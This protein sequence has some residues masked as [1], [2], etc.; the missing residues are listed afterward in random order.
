MGFSWKK[1]LAFAA[2]I[3]AIV[4]PGIGT[5]V[6]A[7]ILGGS[8]AATAAAVG[9]TVAEVTA[10]VGAATIAAGSTALQ[11]GTVEDVFIS[12]ASAGVASGVNFAAGG[13]VTGAAAG[14]VAGT[15]IRGG[16]ASQVLT[17]AFAAGVGAG[18]QDAIPS[19]PD[20]GKTLGS[21]ART[22]ITSG[23]N[24]DQTLLNTAV[25]ALGT[26]D[27]KQRPAPIES[28]TGGQQVDANTIIGP[29]V[30]GTGDQM[31]STLA[32]MMSTQKP[33]ISN[34]D[35]FK[36][37]VNEELLKS[38]F[39][40]TAQAQPLINQAGRIIG[41]AVGAAGRVL[42][43]VA[44]EI[45]MPAAMRFAANNPQYAAETAQYLSKMGMAGA[46]AAVVT[47]FG[48]SGDTIN[49]PS[50]QLQGLIDQ[51]PKSNLPIVKPETFDPN[52]GTGSDPAKT[53]PTIPKVTTTP[54]R[55]TD[56]GDES[57]RLL[58][59]FP[60]PGTAPA[61]DLSV[62][63]GAEGDPIYTELVAAINSGIDPYVAIAEMAG[64]ARGYNED[65]TSYLNDLVDAA[66]KQGLDAQK[67]V[68]AIVNTSVAPEPEIV[69]EPS[70]SP[71]TVPATF[72][73]IA[74]QTS[75]SVSPVVTT[76]PS[77]VP[78]PGTGPAAG[79]L[80]GSGGKIE[81]PSGGPGPILDIVKSTMPDTEPSSGS[82]SATPSSPETPPSIVPTE[83]PGTIPTTDLDIRPGVGPGVEPV[84]PGTPEIPP[85]LPPVTPAE[86]PP[87]VQPPISP[88]P[89]PEPE[90]E[91]EPPPKRQ[92][93]PTTLYPTITQTPRPRKPSYPI[94]A[95]PSPA[96]LLA[97]A[98][99]AYR[100]AGAIEGAESGKERQKVWNEK[101]LRLKDA[102]GL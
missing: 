6:G 83:I 8:A 14:S 58:A 68:D 89:L 87:G 53:K 69:P 16:D 21:A 94:L 38:Q 45:V 75:P 102:L 2:P 18:V 9:L 88:E 78:S 11:G 56:T 46:A 27:D 28:R 52:I 26:L 7:A 70:V 13:G 71:E 23:G 93:P 10:A 91:P 37:F 86:I 67:S 47:S 40:Q 19:N 43:P 92:A 100:P 24:V 97:D 36:S 22:Y 99:A 31:A 15:A 4:V 32:G 35:D 80:I 98:L 65:P 59:R 61:S 33:E 77:S 72:P 12:A 96:R 39:D 74:P 82:S 29:S 66:A 49:L 57:A 5:A 44:E 85:E 62:I 64:E 25:T 76:V 81:G 48:L 17:N 55:I 63:G 54:A 79:V 50:P 1:A 3:A 60:P 51:I 30:A 95:G 41:P 20:V 42:I 90:P 73:E 34:V 101:S 84:I